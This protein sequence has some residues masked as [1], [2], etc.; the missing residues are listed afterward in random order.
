MPPKTMVEMIDD[1]FAI[2]HRSVS[3]MYKLTGILSPDALAE[4]KSNVRLTG[5]AS[6]MFGRR[7]PAQAMSVDEMRRIAELCEE[8]ADCHEQPVNVGSGYRLPS[9]KE[10]PPST[11]V[12]QRRRIQLNR[13]RA[14]MPEFREAAHRIIKMADAMNGLSP[15]KE[16]AHEHHSASV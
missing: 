5:L 9:G 12:V 16:T 3:N 13:I 10:I 6:H 4:L 7:T 14:A 1:Q 2:L 11:H 8:L 15:G